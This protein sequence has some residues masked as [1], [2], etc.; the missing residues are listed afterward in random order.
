MYN[1]L[2]ADVVPGAPNSNVLLDWRFSCL[3]GVLILLTAGYSGM[4]WSIDARCSF[5]SN[6]DTSGV[7]DILMLTAAV[8]S[9]RPSAAEIAVLAVTGVVKSN[10]QMSTL[11][12]TDVIVLS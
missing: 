1:G 2:A 10:L 4:L 8:P 12:W 6:E 3:S 5:I 11:A 7:Y 9:K